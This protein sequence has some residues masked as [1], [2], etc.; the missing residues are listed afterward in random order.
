MAKGERPDRAT[1]ID[2][3]CQLLEVLAEAHARGILHRHLTE[4]EVILTADGRVA[5]TGFGLTRLAFDPLVTPP[6]EQL[7]GGLYTA[8]SDLYMVGSLLRRLAFAAGALR[9]GR[10]SFGVRDPL[11]KVLARATFTDPA[12]R[13]KTA[14][15]MADALREAGRAE[16]VPPPRRW[17]RSAETGA[18][19]ASFPAPSLRL[20]AAEPSSASTRQEREDGELWRALMLLVISLLLMTFVLA[21]G[22]FLR[23]QDGPAGPGGRAATTSSAPATRPAPPAASH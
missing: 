6:P 16:S 22:W 17:D 3:G 2:W 9:G 18:T 23:E 21:T 1:L 11:L 15:E 19:V 14:A 7:V 8:Q 4:E 12:G 5:L 10:G 20:V 13:Y